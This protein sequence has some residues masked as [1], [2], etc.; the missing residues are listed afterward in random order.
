MIRKFFFAATFFFLLLPLSLLSAQELFWESPEI[1]STSNSLFS[2][3]VSGKNICAVVWQEKDSENSY[4]LKGAYS[5]NGRS[6][7]SP[8]TISGPYFLGEENISNFSLCID[9]QDRLF[10]A[11]IKKEK[12]LQ[13]LYSDNGGGKWQ[14]SAEIDYEDAAVAPRIFASQNGGLNLFVTQGRIQEERVTF[15]HSFSETGDNWTNPASIVNS[16]DLKL[17][18]LP[19]MATLAGREYLVFQS[20]YSSKRPTYQLY[21]SSSL[22]NG[23]TWQPAKL[24]TTFEEKTT[25]ENKNFIYYDNQRP[26]LI[27]STDRLF[28]S[29]ERGYLGQKHQIYFW[30]LNSSMQPLS[31]V[32]QISN[33]NFSCLAPRAVYGKDK[34]LVFWFSGPEGGSRIFQAEKGAVNFLRPRAMPDI[35]GRSSFPGP[36]FFRDNYYL[37]WNSQSGRRNRIVILKPDQSAPSPRIIPVNFNP[38]R[39]SQS[40]QISLRWRVASDPSG[41]AGFGYLWNQEKD[42]PK[43]TTLQLLENQNSINLEA[44]NDGIWYFHICAQ[45]YAG[46]W[47]ER[48]RISYTRD[49]TPPG[50]VIFNQAETD[51][52]GFLPSNTFTISWQPPEPGMS[53]YSYA[54]RYLGPLDSDIPIEEAGINLSPPPSRILSRENGAFFRN[55]DNGYWALTVAAYDIAGNKGEANS[56]IFKLDKYIPVTYISYVNGEVDQLGNYSIQVRGRGFLDGGVISELVLDKDGIPPYDYT[57]SLKEDDYQIRSDRLISG[58]QLPDVREGTYRVGL[59]HSL[60][61]RVFSPPV[62]KLEPQGTIVFG[63][64]RYKYKADWNIKEPK[65]FVADNNFLFLVLMM[66]GLFLISII[67]SFNIYRQVLEGRKIQYSVNALISGRRMPAEEIKRRSKK[68][69]KK[70][71][72]LR[73]KF[74]FSITLLLIAVILMVALPLGFYMINNQQKNFEDNLRQQAEVL[75][76]SLASSAINFLPEQA[77]IELRRLPYQITSAKDAVFATITGQG[78]G[79]PADKGAEV[80]EYVWGSNHP[81]LKEKLESGEIEAGRYQLQDEI[82]PLL[83]QLRQELEEKASEAV[84]VHV[85]AINDLRPEAANLALRFDQQSRQRLQ[86]IQAEILVHQTKIRE[87]LD[88]I[89]ENIGAVPDFGQQGLSGDTQLFIFYKPV[90]YESQDDNL[91]YRGMV[92]LGISTERFRQEIASSTFTLLRMTAL[93]ALIAIAIGIV[94]SLILAAIIINPIKKLVKQ[95]ELIRD[96]EDKADLEGHEILLKSRDELAM[97]ADTINDMTHGLVKAAAASKDL[98]LGKEIQKMFIPLETDSTGRKLST[99]R[100]D[101]GFLEFFGYYEGAKGVSGDYFY[102][103][104]FDPDHY[105]VIKCDVAGKGVPAALIMVEVATIFMSFFKDQSKRPVAKIDLAPLVLKINDLVEER[106]FKG[107]FAALSVLVINRKT[108][109]VYFSNAGDNEMLSYNAAERRVQKRKFWE[110]PAAGVFPGDLLEMKGGFKQELFSIKKGDILMLYTDGL[111]EAQRKFRDQNFQL[112]IC[113][114]AGLEKDQEHGNHK[115]GDSFE[116]FSTRRISDVLSAI[117]DKGTYELE[118]F[119]NPLPDERLRFDFSSC[120]DDLDEVVMG[121]ISVEKIFRMVPDPQATADDR[122]MIDLKVEEFLKKHFPGFR[123]YFQE[124]KRIPHPSI[125]EY[126]YYTHL[127]EDE[128]YDDLTVLTIRKK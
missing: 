85:K 46:N 78:R 108:G 28:L 53:G 89:A 40:S 123:K 91:Y 66:G 52:Q 101:D 74:A 45:D 126:V 24:L 48:S 100:T 102:Y 112:M 41:I 42:G 88:R 111:E 61:G 69:K 39:P 105:A 8:A 10:L 107:R 27:S 51:E 117:L 43:P 113:N 6:W 116:E 128:Q 81:E 103:T 64:F 121:L 115:L 62:L 90:L 122:V 3:S 79:V 98:T 99:G 87:A 65:A 2:Q 57:F 84:A 55:R 95:V 118:T 15:Y 9:S 58:I 83:P 104:Q 25:R 97:L 26:H 1:L 34:L 70:G 33:E 86:D 30:E 12:K 4:L 50:P 22:D 127:K 120:S 106:G 35:S 7:T 124:D 38:E 71:F 54:L 5:Q 73:L 72:S 93:I 16:D 18:F 21:F 114:E 76:S 92:R 59:R 32:Q 109:K 47:S 119:H 13:I 14:E 49:T 56:I 77:D 17:N 19:V 23:R 67:L 110:V 29:W 125:P 20:L 31:S 11:C 68:M 36:H 60:R 94:G 82:T 63:D 96:T 44:L 80:F 37:F 75:L